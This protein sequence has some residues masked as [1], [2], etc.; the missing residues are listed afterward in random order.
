MSQQV[1]ELIDKIKSEGI[2]TAEEKSREI[3]SQAQA[4]SQKIINDAKSQAEQM[5]IEAKEEIKKMQES[6]QMA[7]KQAS[8]D[9]LLSLRKEIENT[10][11]KII[12]SQVNEALSSENLSHILS[13]VIEK[14]AEKKGADTD[15]QIALKDEDLKSLKDGFTAKL[16][17]KLKQSI[18]LQ[19]AE[20]ISG[21][22]TI[23]YDGGKS[24]FDFTDE[25][26]AKYLGAYLNTQVAELVKDAV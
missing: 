12:V 9:T 2:Q 14:T 8:R 17:D 10:L 25:S 19:A 3:E 22:F 18:K 5:I 13:T 16:Q 24:S 7:L 15:I 1:Q 6:T 26:L 23:S 4:Q 20:D 11:Q 21:G